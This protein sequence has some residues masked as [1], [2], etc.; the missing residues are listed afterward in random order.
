MKILVAHNYYQQ[1]GGEDQVF[2]SEAA[3]LEAHG[4]DV[5]RWTRHNDAINQMRGLSAARATL[6]NHSSAAELAELVRRHRPQVVHFHNTFPLISPA[7]YYAARAGGAAV[8]Q[9]LHNYRLLCP[10]ALFFRD[11]RVC[12]DCLGKSIPWPGVVHKCYRGSRS[13]SAAVT[14]MV[15][16]HRALGTWRTGVDAYIALTRFSREKFIQGG[17]P[18]DKIVVKPNFVHPDPAAGQGR[19]G[20]GVFVGRLSPEKGLPTLL[21]AWKSLGGGVPLKVVGDG[22]L[23]AAVQEAVAGGSAIEWLGR[24]PIQEVYSL[25]GEAMFLVLPSQCYETFGRTIVEAFATGTPVIAPR[26]GAMAELVQHGRTGWHF[27]PGDSLDLAAKV[28][29]LLLATPAA[30]AQMRQAARQEYERNYTAEPNYRA[31]MAIYQQACARHS[32][33]AGRQRAVPNLPHGNG[34]A[35]LPVAGV[36]P[37]TSPGGYREILAT[38]A[39]R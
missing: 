13:A 23:A 31:L 7:A 29:A 2:S 26:L 27:E 16:A 32:E 30:R 5:V 25:I 12:E 22:P 34:S 6:W 24:R 18:P 28:R 33:H 4:D 14:A 39:D 38:D 20:Y 19:G 9:T 3:L 1:A 11:G 17:L 36:E 15:T 10:N 35:R 8:V 21:K 37:E